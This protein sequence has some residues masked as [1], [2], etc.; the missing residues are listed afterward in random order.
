MKTTYTYKVRLYKSCK[1]VL[2]DFL[3]EAFLIQKGG[4]KMKYFKKLV[5]DRIYL[6]P[7]NA[8]DLEK[9]TEWMNDFQITD[10]TGRSGMLVTLDSEKK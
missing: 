1:G 3:C 5:G 4:M 2:K 6:S 8:E 10:Y 9:F 7:R